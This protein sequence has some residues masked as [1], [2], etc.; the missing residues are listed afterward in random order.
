MFFGNSRRL[1]DYFVV[2]KCGLQ[3]RWGRLPRTFFRPF[4]AARQALAH[5]FAHV[6]FLTRKR[7]R[8]QSITEREPW[9]TGEQEKTHDTSAGVKVSAVRLAF[10]GT[11][12]ADG[13]KY[14]HNI[15]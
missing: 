9:L 4:F 14:L 1:I 6:G 10:T 15:P 13:S 2:V 5:P 7:V 12:R 8:E 11:S 3:W